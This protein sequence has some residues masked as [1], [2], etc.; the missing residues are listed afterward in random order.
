M[1]IKNV[2]STLTDWSEVEKVEYKGKKGTSYWQTFE[3]G[4]IRVRVVEYASGFESD[5]WCERGHVLLVLEGRLGIRLKDGR[6]FVLEPGVS[7]QVEDNSS[8]PH[9]AFTG[10]GAKVFIVD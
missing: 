10:E 2:P 9:L 4:N 5:H 7:F 6:E 3:S 1:N 8:N